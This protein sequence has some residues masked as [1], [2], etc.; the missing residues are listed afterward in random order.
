MDRRQQTEGDVSEKSKCA[1]TSDEQS[2]SRQY[3]LDMKYIPIDSESALPSR[4]SMGSDE[5]LGVGSSSQTI[6]LRGSVQVLFA[7]PNLN[8]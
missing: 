5:T 8:F 6:P 4:L 7:T 1:K 3:R 2:F